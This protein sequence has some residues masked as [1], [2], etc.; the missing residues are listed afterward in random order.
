MKNKKF[1][2]LIM[3]GAC[4]IHMQSIAALS[5]PSTQLTPAINLEQANLESNIHKAI[6]QKEQDKK[7]LSIDEQAKRDINLANMIKRSHR[8]QAK[9]IRMKK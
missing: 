8:N 5:I 4:A 9:L 1:I 3:V 7:T 6:A 2:G